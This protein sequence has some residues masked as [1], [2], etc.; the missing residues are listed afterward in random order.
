MTRII[1]KEAN[2]NLRNL[3][4]LRIKLLDWRKGGVI[5]ISTRFN[6]FAVKNIFAIGPV[7]RHFV[8]YGD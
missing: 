2:S 1:I 7:L 3:C 6:A 8:S 5:S 4:N